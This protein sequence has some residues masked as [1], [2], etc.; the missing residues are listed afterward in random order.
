M[1]VLGGASAWCH[2]RDHIVKLSRLNGCWV[3]ATLGPCFLDVSDLHIV[4][5]QKGMVGNGTVPPVG[6]VSVHCDVPR[7][8]VTRPYSF[9]RRKRPLLKIVSHDGTLPSRGVRV[10]IG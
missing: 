4:G 1:N 8:T 10:A 6:G 3:V 2:A 5:Y 9:L 7:S